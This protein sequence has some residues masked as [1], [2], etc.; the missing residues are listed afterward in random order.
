MTSFL[1]LAIKM[2]GKRP[3]KFNMRMPGGKILGKKME[4]VTSYLAI[5]QTIVDSMSKGN[6]WEKV[7]KFANLKKMG[8][9]FSK[10]ATSFNFSLSIMEVNVC[11]CL[12]FLVNKYVLRLLILS[13]NSFFFRHSL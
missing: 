12:V 4:E 3:A 10:I 9:D 1:T 5:M 2:T 8:E 7:K 6:N 11:L 13:Q